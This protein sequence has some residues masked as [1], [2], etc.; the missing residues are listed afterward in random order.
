M[1]VLVRFKDFQAFQ[2]LV[3]YSKWLK[4]F[5]LFDLCL[6]PVLHFHLLLIFEIPMFV[7]EMSR[8]KE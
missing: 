6:E 2:L 3:E 1:S 7:V 4:S 5:G 8:T